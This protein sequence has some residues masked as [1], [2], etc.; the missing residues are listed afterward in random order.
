MSKRNDND[1]VRVSTRLL[2]LMFCSGWAALLENC[3]L[4]IACFILLKQ[5]ET[6]W[7]YHVHV[8][9]VNNIDEKRKKRYTSIIEKSIEVCTVIKM[10]DFS[11]CL[12]VTAFHCFCVNFVGVA[13]CNLLS[14]PHVSS[15]YSRSACSSIRT[16]KIRTLHKCAANF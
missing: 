3:I 5:I 10:P 11:S 14:L 13:K 1:D 2:R 16:M 15:L 4:K 7:W 9:N 8:N 6:K 12:Y